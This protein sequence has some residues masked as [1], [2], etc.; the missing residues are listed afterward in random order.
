[1]IYRKLISGAEGS[2]TRVLSGDR[3]TMWK[4]RYR[5]MW[6]FDTQV[7]RHDPRRG[8]VIGT[9]SGTP[10]LYA[11]DT[12]TGALRQLTHRPLGVQS[13]L[14]SPDGRDV[15]YFADDGGNEIG[16]YVRIPWSGGGEQDVTPAMERYTALYRCAV[17][18]AG[19]L[20]AFAPTTAGGCLLYCIDFAEGGKI[21]TPRLIH[22]DAGLMHKVTLSESGT[23]VAVGSTERSRDRRYIVLVFAT[24]DGRRVGELSHLPDGSVVPVAFSPR[25]GDTRLLVRSNRSGFDRPLIWDPVTDAC[26]AV[27]LR[28]LE[29]DV[30]PLDWSPDG[31]RLLLC[32]I[33]RAV[34]QLYVYSMS[35]GEI[36]RLDH[37]GGVYYRP[38][39]RNAYFDANGDI[40]ALWEDSAHPA[41]LI[42]LDGQTGERKRTILAPDHMPPSHSLH[43]VS[44]RSSDGELIQAWLGVP[45]GE[46]PFPAIIEAHAGWQAA[47]DEFNPAPQTWLDQG[48]AY[49]S[50]NYR[51]S[52][53]FGRAFQ[54]KIW[55]NIG[56][57]EA[58][59]VAAG[60]NWLVE[61]SIARADAVII[62]GDSYGGYVALMTLG[63]HADLWAGGIALVAGADFV[64]DAT[65]GSDW[66][67]RFLQTM[68]GGPLEACADRYVRSSP[69][70]YAGAVTAPVLIIQGRNDQRWSAAGMETYVRELHRL[71]KAV[72]IDWFD[73]GHRELNGLHLIAIQERM[74]DFADE[75]WG[76]ASV[77]DRASGDQPAETGEGFG[78]TYTS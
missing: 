7:C 40:F 41:Q 47:G 56:H 27:T 30:M 34:Q 60:R 23:V 26:L 71:G 73:G 51:G 52:T 13:A 55:G 22:R 59:D 77:R 24:A 67:R 32:Q 15:Y 63:K 39:F 19:N 78:L 12:E 43:S 44:F 20:F 66:T 64:T 72:D 45:P 18:S 5:A 53:T 62:A 16:H 6:L 17:S 10:Q 49:L 76:G 57:W 65:C 29:G 21:G 3:T 42:E 61:Q 46:R 70:T 36:D 4:E 54:E 50:V 37:Q 2:M 25:P 58:E 11:W 28:E 33:D 8:V 38:G 31:S 68:L 35:T 48:Y 1:M 9:P 69:I 14:L 74:L 75:V